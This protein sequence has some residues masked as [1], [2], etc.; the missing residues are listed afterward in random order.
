MIGGLEFKDP[1]ELGVPVALIGSV[2][3]GA[4]NAAVTALAL[5]LSH[6]LVPWASNS[7]IEAVV[8]GL[9]F[10]LLFAFLNKEVVISIGF[11]VIN[12]G[13]VSV[14][15]ALASSSVIAVGVSNGLAAAALAVFQIVNAR[16]RQRRD[17]D[18]DGT[19]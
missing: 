12:A 6:F 10:A 8:V 14:A 16:R 18:A 3:F 17:E 15:G 19:D 5:G 1:S 13:V 4:V 9:V 2:V 7:T 11:G